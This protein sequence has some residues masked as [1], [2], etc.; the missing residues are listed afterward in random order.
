MI[1][2]YSVA[3]LYRQKQSALCGTNVYF[4]CANIELTDGMEFSSSEIH[5]YIHIPTA[6]HIIR[7][8]GYF[9][10]IHEEVGQ[11]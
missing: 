11:L 7:T 8:A 9:P 1:T 2:P 4:R 3:S 10:E 5:A 6:S